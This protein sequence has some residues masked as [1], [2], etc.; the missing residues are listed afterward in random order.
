M[1][2]G[3]SQSTLEAVVGELRMA[4][5]SLN[6]NIQELGAWLQGRNSQVNYLIGH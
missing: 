4:M 5:V 3:E 1:V 6:G 2:G